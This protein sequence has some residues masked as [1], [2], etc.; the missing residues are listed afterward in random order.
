MVGH[1][2]LVECTLDGRFS[3]KPEKW[4][5]EQNSPRLPEFQS[6]RN[7]RVTVTMFAKVRFIQR[8]MRSGNISRKTPNLELELIWRPKRED[9]QGT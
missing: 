5:D 8:V 3:V 1:S 4:N 6:E 7:P 2:T 9:F